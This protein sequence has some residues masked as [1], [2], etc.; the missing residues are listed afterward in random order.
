L[1]R[2]VIADLPEARPVTEGVAE[3]EESDIAAGT[4]GCRQRGPDPAP[5]EIAM[6]S[7]KFKMRAAL[8]PHPEERSKIASRRM[9][10][11]TPERVGAS[12]ETPLHGSSG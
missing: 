9:L 2:V 5:Y 8:N 11:M 3:V 4:N 10:Q 7:R 1:K 12:F 6:M